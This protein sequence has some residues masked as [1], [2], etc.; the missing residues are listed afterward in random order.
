M[1]LCREVGSTCL[2]TSLKMDG[3]A[4]GDLTSVRSFNVVLLK[5]P[6]KT[7]AECFPGIKVGPKRK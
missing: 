4:S 5:D 3:G 1:S 2:P 6:N 7:L